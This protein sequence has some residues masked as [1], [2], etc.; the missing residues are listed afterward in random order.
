MLDWSNLIIKNTFKIKE[1]KNIKNNIINEGFYGIKTINY[2]TLNSK[3]SINFDRIL[4]KR[5]KRL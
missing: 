2:G 5:Y 4:K 1:K 3:I